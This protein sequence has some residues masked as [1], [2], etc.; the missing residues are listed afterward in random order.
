MLN[1]LLLTW[2]NQKEPERAYRILQEAK[3]KEGPDSWRERRKQVMST[4]RK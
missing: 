2:V 1:L 3:L 4:Q